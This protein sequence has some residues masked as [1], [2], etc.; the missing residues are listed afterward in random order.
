MGTEGT[1]RLEF[2]DWSVA[3][4]ALFRKDRSE[5]QVHRIPTARDTMFRVEDEEFLRFAS[6][7]K[8]FPAC[9]LE[10]AM[11]S[12]EVLDRALKRYTETVVS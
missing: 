1:L 4:L 9:P 3:E 6:G 11:K 7:E 5:W 10:E 8:V 2:A 12:L